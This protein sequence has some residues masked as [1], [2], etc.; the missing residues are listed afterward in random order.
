MRPSARRPEGFVRVQQLFILVHLFAPACPSPLVV[1]P[2][3]LQP[4]MP[5]KPRAVINLDDEDDGLDDELLQCSKPRRGRGQQGGM[6]TTFI[7]RPAGAAAATAAPKAGA[8]ASPSVTQ[9]ALTRDR[10]EPAAQPQRMAEAKA[11]H[12]SVAAS[13]V[14]AERAPPQHTCQEAP[15]QLEP[16]LGLWDAVPHDVKLLVGLDRLQSSPRT[17]ENPKRQ[18]AS[19][20]QRAGG[21]GPERIS[22]KAWT[23]LTGVRAPEPPRPR[24][25]RMRQPRV[26][27]ARLHFA[28]ARPDAGA[29]TR[30]DFDGWK[31]V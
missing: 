31:D 3:A 17:F 4:A 10:R 1:R 12:C 14:P 18:S 29:S 25:D 13:A 19:D 26:C 16:S 23:A 24:E 9:R 20:S 27:G 5:R 2:S 7:A 22:V 15:Q 28:H 21:A 30:W 6:T 8:A 11:F